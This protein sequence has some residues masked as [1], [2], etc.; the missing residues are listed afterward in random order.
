MSPDR[1]LRAAGPLLVAAGLVVIASVSLTARERPENVRAL[2][3]FGL[4]IAIGEVLRITLSGGR[5][6]APLASAGAVAFALLP[7]YSGDVLNHPDAALVVTVVTVASVFGAFPSGI[8]GRGM[9]VDE[10]ARRVLTTLIAALSF[11]WLLTYTG[12]NAAQPSENGT[13][14]ALAMTLS[15]IIAAV[16]DAV[17]AAAV[18]SSESRSPFR[19]AVVDEF[20]ALLGIA[21]AISATGVLI[22]LATPRMGYLALPIFAVPLLLTQ[23]SFRRYATI[24]RTYL[25]TIRSL[26]KVTEVGGYTE[27]G[28]SQRVSR[29]AVTIGR[30]M[31][32][33]ERDLTD[34]EYAALMHDIGQLSLTDPIPG[35]ATMLV[36][37]VMQRRI[38][39]LAITDY[40]GGIQV[41][42][43]GPRSSSSARPTP[44]ARIAD[45]STQTSPSRVGSSRLSTPT[46]ISSERLWRATASWPRSSSC[47][48]ESTG[49]TTRQWSTHWRAS[50][51]VRTSTPSD[52]QCQHRRELGRL[53]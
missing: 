50:S 8:V 7:S 26:S 42:S 25:Q 3:A 17:L 21:S 24:D 51:S 39:E 49:S 29:L 35:G 27:K 10:L 9:H 44:T 43:T 22:A 33:S 4:F 37:P 16:T 31:G 5:Q 41:R 15:A 32:V 1:E 52:A 23:F 11:S 28:H 45:T 19:I 40:Q 36:A 14:L 18:R 38:A 20:R 12:W 30:E 6:T 46:T 47:S 34:L 48:S 53:G 2:V 13:Q